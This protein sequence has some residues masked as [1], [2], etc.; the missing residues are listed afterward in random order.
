MNLGPAGMG[1][2]TYVLCRPR[3]WVKAL[4]AIIEYHCKERRYEQ[5]NR[6]RDRARRGR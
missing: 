3:L 4:H 1:A 5:K 6:M 2:M